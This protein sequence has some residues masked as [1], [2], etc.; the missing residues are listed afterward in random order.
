MSRVAG[1]W[2]N[3][4]L[5]GLKLVVNLF[6][7][8]LNESIRNTDNLSSL[9]EHYSSSGYLHTLR[10]FSPQTLHQKLLHYKTCATDFS[11]TF[12]VIKK[13]KSIPKSKAP[14]MK[15]DLTDTSRFENNIVYQVWIISCISPGN[16]L[17]SWRALIL[18]HIT[19]QLSK[20]PDFGREEICRLIQDPL[21]GTNLPRIC[22]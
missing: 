3:Y 2:F 21:I 7:A 4:S 12:I 11:L 10:I 1:W 19:R 14:H 5:P 13:K 16:S 22:G 17:R 15:Y 18:V 20:G 6:H 8:L 9:E